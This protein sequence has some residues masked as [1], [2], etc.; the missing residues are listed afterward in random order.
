MNNSK[1]SLNY[2]VEIKEEGDVWGK[3]CMKKIPLPLIKK[4][5]FNSQGLYHKCRQE[6]YQKLKETY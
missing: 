6:I 3:L 2:K 5:I 1:K 4:N